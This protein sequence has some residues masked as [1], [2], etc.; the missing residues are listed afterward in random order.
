MKALLLLTTLILMAPAVQ[1]ATH[2]WKGSGVST[3]WSYGP[4]WTSGVAPTAA[5]SGV[6]LIFPTTSFLI[7]VDDIVDLKVDTMTVSGGDYTFSGLGG[8]KLTF[9]GSEIESL[10]QNPGVG[11]TIT[12]SSSL[13]IVLFGSIINLSTIS[14]SLTINAVISGGGALIRKEVLEGNDGSGTPVT[15]GGTAANTFMGGIYNQGGILTLSKPA[16]VKVM[17]GG[18]LVMETGTSNHSF[19][20]LTRANQLPAATAVTIGNGGRLDLAS[21]ASQTIGGLQMQSGGACRVGWDGADCILTLNGNVTGSGGTIEG[22]G[23]L[24]LGGAPRTFTTAA[25]KKLN[26]RITVIDGVGGAG[27]ILKQ[28]DGEMLLT[29]SFENTFTGP[30]LVS[31]G[32]LAVEKPLALGSAAAGT[33]VSAGAVLKVLDAISIAEPLALNSGRL[34]A[35]IPGSMTS[36]WTGPISVSG[37][38]TLSPDGFFDSG[39]FIS[40]VISGTGSL[41]V[42]GPRPIEF[43]GSQSNTLTGTIYLQSGKLKLNKTGAVAIRGNLEI[44][45]Q[46]LQNPA[47]IV[48]LQPNQIFDTASI[49]LGDAPANLYDLGGFPD[50][51]GSLA[52]GGTVSLG[53]GSL[54]LGG[55]NATTEFHGVMSGAGSNSLIKTG[56]GTFTINPAI[57]NGSV[58]HSTYTGQTYV[59]NG[60]LEINDH[61]TG[62]IRVNG[63]FLKGSG[64]AGIVTI[65]LGGQL[66]LCTLQT[67][68]LNILPG[69]AG[70]SIN[71]D[72]TTMENFDHLKVNGTVKLTNS[73]LSASLYFQPVNG[74]VF[75]II[76]NDGSDPVQGY[77]NGLPNGSL[78][79][80][81]GKPF[82]IYYNGGDGNDVVLTY[83]GDIPV[84]VKLLSFDYNSTTNTFAMQY[85]GNPGQL[86]QWQRSTDLQTWTSA[87]S[88]TANILG[89]ITGDFANGAYKPAKLFYRLVK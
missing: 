42:T 23:Q 11:K 17:G 20:V 88:S 76:D 64:W 69:S 54:S 48:C 41:V 39:F 45:T 50:T 14:G 78:L 67:A 62:S 82:T 89:V 72:L 36:G 35:L 37:I 86:Y 19:C 9:T 43:S 16:G 58:M 46:N 56:T 47:Q 7:S 6:K 52:G 22:L 21:G 26:L 80:I 8:A 65:D 53:A 24:S 83:L 1:A 77:F 44:D 10:V 32:M 30:V 71:A 60:T 12:I 57:I 2:T 68:G 70:N 61:Q 3:L 27:G 66:C 15:L 40:G 79:T 59:N 34:T 63:G 29:G 18:D 38:S 73:S 49:L 84:E 25:G 75:T 5:E 74:T 13:P 4:N 51:I 33:T 28:G 81:S 55:N 85:L 31:A 87:G